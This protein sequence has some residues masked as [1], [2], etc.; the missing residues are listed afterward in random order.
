MNLIANKK[1][2]FIGVAVA[3]VLVIVFVVGAMVVRNSQTVTSKVSSSSQTLVANTSLAAGDKVTNSATVELDLSNSTVK[4]PTVTL[5]SNPIL[6]GASLSAASSVASSIVSA[7]SVASIASSASV[8]NSDPKSPTNMYVTNKDYKIWSVVWT[9]T[10]ATIGKLKYGTTS[11]NLDKVISDDRVALANKAAYSH[12]VTITNADTL[13]NQGNPTFYYK[14]LS[15]DTEYGNGSSAYTYSNAP[16]LSSPSSPT[17]AV[18]TVS[19][20]VSNNDAIVIG[21]IKSG[22]D[23]S[24]WVS[25]AVSGTNS[26]LNIG[27]ARK[28]DLKSYM[29]Q[30]STSKL[31]VSVLGPNGKV[32]G[33]KTDIS[34]TNI[35]DTTI[36]VTITPGTGTVASIASSRAS[37]TSVKT[38]TSTSTVIQSVSTVTSVTSSLK[39]VPK[40]AIEDDLSLL[41]ILI[42]SLTILI[43]GTSGLYRI[44][45]KQ[46]FGRRVLEGNDD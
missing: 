2:L 3:F 11:S 19:A 29:A 32:I 10:T 27:T 24:E 16:L 25:S 13:L 41:A 30:G 37:S 35:E 28:N 40:T 31:E 21:R 4:L 26:I 44:N 7:S 1:I 17:N 45:A 33:T 14:I 12:Q 15:D 18:V 6:A 5:S 22:T 39:T 9:T 34:L 42:F 8:N 46:N 43:F 23:Y 38:S 20:A 36:A